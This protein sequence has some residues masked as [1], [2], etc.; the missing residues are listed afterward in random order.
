MPAVF[1]HVSGIN[2][3]GTHTKFVITIVDQAAEAEAP[4]HRTRE[5]THV[6]KNRTGKGWPDFMPLDDLHS[7][8]GYLA[9]DRLL[10]RT[11]VEVLP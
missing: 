5:I 4:H 8:P 7:R 1:L 2:K 3:G 6:F 9:G 11:H 10:V